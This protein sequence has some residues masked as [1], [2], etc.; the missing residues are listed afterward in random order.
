[1][2]VIGRKPKDITGKRY[3]RLTAKER[4]N[5]KSG[6]CYI[7]LCCCDCGKT[8][9]TPVNRLEHGDIKS[10]GCLLHEYIDITGEIYG[11]LKVVSYHGNKHRKSLWNCLCVCG[12]KCI[13]SYGDLVSGNTQ[14]CGCKKSETMRSMYVA[15]TNVSKLLNPK[16]RTTNTSGVTGVSYNKSRNRWEAEITFQGKRY[17]LGRYKEKEEAVKARRRAEEELHGEFIKWYK[18]CK[19]GLDNNEQ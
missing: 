12:N 11:E 4:T 7:W 14:S 6:N 3:G 9:E 1:M 8:I 13:V 2:I 10:C 18:H 5:R 15:K 16:L 17:R 19:K